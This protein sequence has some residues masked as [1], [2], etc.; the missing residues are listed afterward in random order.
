MSK[1]SHQTLKRDL[2]GNCKV[3]NKDGV[4]MFYCARKRADWYVKRNLA[5]VL[6]EDPFEVQLTFATNGPGNINDPYYLQPGINRCVVCGKTDDLT[7][8][9]IVPISF[10]RHMSDDVKNH[11]YHDILP[12]CADHHNEY[13]THSNEFRKQ[14]EEEYSAPFHGTFDKERDTSLRKCRAYASA[15]VYHG[16]KI[17]DERKRFIIQYIKETLGEDD[18]N[19]LAVSKMSIE[20]NAQSQGKLIVE[21][22]TDVAAFIQRWR[23]HFVE[24]M[25]PKYLPL[26]W[27]ISRDKR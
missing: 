3:R 27:N 25:C 10:R 23:A 6:N 21:K 2:Y 7:R 12:I 11:S 14:L 13:E 24:K 22:L 26:F 17:P 15:V 5:V 20:T 16:D 18:I 9:H 19:L 8:H 1:H 4:I